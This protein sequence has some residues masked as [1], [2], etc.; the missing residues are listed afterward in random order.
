MGRAET[1]PLPAAEDLSVKSPLTK[2]FEEFV[3]HEL[4]N[5]RELVIDLSMPTDTL[6]T[7][8]II[9]TELD[10]LSTSQ[11][12]R[13]IDVLVAQFCDDEKISPRLQTVIIPYSP[14]E[15]QWLTIKI[16]R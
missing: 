6:I 12:I 11:Q 8:M 1:K 9:A 5:D 2:R 3:R 16:G 4:A 7:G 15:R 13:F 14:E 10:G